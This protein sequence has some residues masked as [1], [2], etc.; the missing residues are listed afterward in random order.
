MSV[1]GVG[2]LPKWKIALI[3][4][5]YCKYNARLSQYSTMKLKYLINDDND[6][7]ENYL[8]FK[9]GAHIYY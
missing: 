4:Q 5:Q 9:R 7:E 1:S 6:G 8:D 3:T 2:I